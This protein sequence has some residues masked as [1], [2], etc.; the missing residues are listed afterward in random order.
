MKINTSYCMRSIDTNQYDGKNPLSLNFLYAVNAMDNHL[1]ASQFSLE[2]V[3]VSQNVM[4]YSKINGHETL[5][6]INGI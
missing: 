5:S 4:T 3:D 2:I 1:H 6:Q